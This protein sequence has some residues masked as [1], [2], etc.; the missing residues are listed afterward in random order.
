MLAKLY[1]YQSNVFPV[2]LPLLREIEYS[3]TG[4]NSKL[5]ELDKAIADL[6]DKSLVLQRLQN[7]GFITAEEFRARNDALAAQRA[8]LAAERKRKLSGSKAHEMIEKIEELQAALTSW[9][10]VPTEFDIDVFDEIV[11]KII[12][13]E[14]GTLR[15]RLRCG[16]E[17]KEAMPL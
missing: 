13:A 1:Y 11:E 3:Q 6:N 14:D 5:F 12:P 10:G 7:K 8:K 17:L 2:S 9:P 4:S 16:L 15:F